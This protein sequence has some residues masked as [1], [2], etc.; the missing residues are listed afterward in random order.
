[1]C[2]HLLSLCVPLNRLSFPPQLEP[3]RHYTSSSVSQAISFSF[4][5]SQSFVWQP[6][7]QSSHY[8]C[9]PHFSFFFLFFTPHALLTTFS[10]SS[11]FSYLHSSTLHCPIPYCRKKAT[12]PL[13]SV[14]TLPNWP[15]HV[16]IV[17]S[18]IPT[19]AGDV[20]RTVGDAPTQISAQSVNRG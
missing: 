8:Y 3:Y 6:P 10:F 11:S 5:L 16:S 14:T 19:F 18:K 1:M 7:F 20:P 12:S 17:P 15:I 13:V 4:L 9:S 2:P